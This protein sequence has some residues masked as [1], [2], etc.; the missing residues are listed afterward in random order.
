[1]FD[2]SVS[3]PARDAYAPEAAVGPSRWTRLVRAIAA[4]YRARRA[5]REL[6]GLDE[7]MLRDIGLD[8]GG[9]AYAVRFGRE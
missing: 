2:L 8:P 6:H 1:M 5:M 3:C 4:E 7:K 9:I